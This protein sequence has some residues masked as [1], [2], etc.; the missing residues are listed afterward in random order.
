ML[1][2]N[3][4]HRITYRYEDNK[5][6]YI[7]LFAKDLDQAREAFNNLELSNNSVIQHIV[8]YGSE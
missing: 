1:D 8:L 2:H 3:T 5:L 7:D 4:E 6:Y